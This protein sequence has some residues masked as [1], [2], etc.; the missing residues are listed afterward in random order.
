MRSVRSEY[1]YVHKRVPTI[2]DLN[3]AIAVVSKH[4]D[5]KF[6]CCYLS[7]TT[8]KQSVVMAAHGFVGTWEVNKPIK[9]SFFRNLFDFLICFTQRSDKSVFTNSRYIQNNGLKVFGCFVMF[10]LTTEWA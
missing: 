2:L 6:S 4:G 5:I 7:C 8:A 10:Y 1:T 3:S 9:Y